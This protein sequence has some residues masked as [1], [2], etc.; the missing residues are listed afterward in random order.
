MALPWWVAKITNKQNKP[1]NFSLWS[2][3][4]PV[5]VTNIQLLL[6][7]ISRIN[8]YTNFTVTMVIKCMNCTVT[9]FPSEKSA[10]SKT[11]PDQTVPY[12]LQRKKQSVAPAKDSPRI[13]PPTG[14]L[15][16]LRYESS[17]L[18]YSLLG[19]IRSLAANYWT[20]INNKVIILAQTLY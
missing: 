4:H 8:S 17:R 10:R 16:P 7:N 9:L 3:Y 2:L 13:P 1:A 5:L 12:Q 11:A 18:M 6:F 15:S 20:P 14:D 19:M